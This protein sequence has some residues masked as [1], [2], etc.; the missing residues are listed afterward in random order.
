M[1]LFFGDLH[2]HTVYSDGDLLPEDVVDLA[3]SQGYD[4]ICITDHNEVNGAY[5]ARDYASTLPGAPTVLIGEEI[6][7][8][9]SG[10]HI[11]AIGIEDKILPGNSDQ[12][13]CNLIHAQ[14]GAAVIAHPGFGNIFIDPA[15]FS[16][17]IQYADGAEYFSLAIGEW[18]NTKNFSII[19]NSDAHTKEAFTLAYTL[20]K[21]RDVLQAIR[22]QNIAYLCINYGKTCIRYGLWG[23]VEECWIPN[24][25]GGCLLS[26]K[27]GK[28]FLTTVGMLGGVWLGCSLITR[29]PETKRGYE[30]VFI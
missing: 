16:Q 11:L 20:Y 29:K 2:L 10:Q 18:N 15:I 13:T 5:V 25:R 30:K 12:E 3:K 1:E 7:P 21:E 19:A 22:N 8:T 9:A 27:T 6:T 28:A 14:G 4:V 26:A 24:F 23:F 17:A